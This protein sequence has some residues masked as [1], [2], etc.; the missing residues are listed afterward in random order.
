MLNPSVKRSVDNFVGSVVN[1]PRTATSV[2]LDNTDQDFQTYFNENQFINKWNKIYNEKVS[3]MQDSPKYSSEEIQTMV[4]QYAK[5]KT[6]GKRPS[7]DQIRGYQMGLQERKVGK[8]TDEEKDEIEKWAKSRLI[9]VSLIDN[10]Y[11]P[12]LTPDQKEVAEQVVKD[13]IFTGI[14][15]EQTLTGVSRRSAGKSTGTK[16]KSEI[17]KKQNYGLYTQALASWYDATTKGD[18]NKINAMLADK[19]YVATVSG[20]K[21]SIAKNLGPEEIKG[22]PT[23][24]IKYGSPIQ[25]NDLRSLAPYIGYAKGTGTKSAEAYDVFDAQKAAY[26]ADQNAINTGAPSKGGS[27]PPSKGGYRPPSKGGKP[28]FN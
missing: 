15:N 1:D 19:G 12:E 14:P 27:T 6:K 11:Q 5:R 28:P 18:V 26:E 22:I 10:T 25:I 8:L 4:D 16:S 24:K 17:I 20:G 23:G 13:Q 21:V 9:K 7:Q 2:L 3:E